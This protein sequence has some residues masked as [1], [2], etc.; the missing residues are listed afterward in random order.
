MPLESSESRRLTKFPGKEERRQLSKPLPDASLGRSQKAPEK[1]DPAPIPSRIL[2]S[3]SGPATTKGSLP[4][5][6]KRVQSE[7][8]LTIQDKNPW[9]TY[10]PLRNITRGGQT[11][12]ACT[13]SIPVRIV[14]LK[15]VT[16]AT[17]LDSIPN[18]CKSP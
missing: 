16:V 12:V 6:S 4:P 10:R 11:K 2:I 17:Q 14:T 1:E 7:S 3:A 15:G 13:R 8:V 5:I 9:L 18:S